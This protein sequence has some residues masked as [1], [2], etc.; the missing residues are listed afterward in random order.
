MRKVYTSACCIIPPENKWETIQEIRQKYDRQIH[1]WMPHINLLY[2]FRPE[3]Q[4]GNAERSLLNIC[5]QIK[6]FQI[7]FKKFRYFE[8]R[9][10]NFTL[11]LE[12]EPKDLVIKLQSELLKGFPDCN[13][14]NKFQDGFTP[15]LSVGQLRG[16][17]NLKNV[18]FQLQRSWKE[19]I[20]DIKEIYFIS[21]E[22]IKTSRFHV[23]K[24][25][26]LNS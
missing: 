18:M 22:N 11:W 7:S 26:P 5:S 1:R 16:P 23:K 10:G 2:P 24:T 14:L 12:P 21:R 17:K 20:C 4:F 8:H 13:D 19:L 15:H 25:I 9:H 3:D 6:S